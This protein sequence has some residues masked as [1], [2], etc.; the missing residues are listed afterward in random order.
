MKTA[1]CLLAAALSLA[2]CAASQRSALPTFS[3]N[4]HAYNKL[5]TSQR[6]FQYGNGQ[7]DGCLTSPPISLA[8]VDAANDSIVGFVREAGTAKA[9]AYATVQLSLPDSAKSILLVASPTGR[10]TFSRTC[11]VQRLDVSFVGYQPLSV[12][13]AS[14][15]LF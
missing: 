8:L 7:P 3:Y 5:I 14:Q 4:A 12:T 9:V 1:A 6:R 11:R 15:K 13:L 10:F 2:G